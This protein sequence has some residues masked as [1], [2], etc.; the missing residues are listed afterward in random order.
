MK[1]YCVKQKKN[2]LNAPSRVDMRRQKMED[3]T[4]GAH[5]LNV[6]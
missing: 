5:V 4:F 3:I 1:S 2:R 6:E